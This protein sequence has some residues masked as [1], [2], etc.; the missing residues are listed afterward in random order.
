MIPATENQQIAE[1]ESSS[2]LAARLDLLLQHAINTEQFEADMVRACRKDPE[3]IW[4]LL[5]LLDQ[6]HRLEALPTA[7]F[8]SLKASADRLGL[9]RRE[10]YLPSLTTPPRPSASAAVPAPPPANAPIAPPAPNPALSALQSAPPA[11]PPPLASAITEPPE[12]PA[13]PPPPA[14]AITELPKPA[15]PP[16]PTPAITP[17]AA[18]EP[19]AAAQAIAAAAA[20]AEQHAAA[21]TLNVGSVIGGRYRVEAELESDDRGRIFQALDQQ[22]AGQPAA[23]CQVA[24]HCM[25]PDPANFESILAERR[26]EFQ[27]AQPLSHPNVLSVRELDQDGLYIYL[28]M[29]LMRGETLAALL[30]RRQGRAL[31][32]SAAYA[33]IRDLGAAL[34]YAHDHG[35]VHG[36][37][38]PQCIL[39]SPAGELRV[40]GFG[41]QRASSCYASGEQLENR[42]PDRRDDLYSLACISYELLRGSHPFDRQNASTAR[43]RGMSAARPVRLSGGQWRALRMG[44]AWRRE[45]RNISIARWIGRMHLKA[46]SK[47]LPML[48]DLMAMPAPRRAWWPWILV[49]ACLAAAAIFSASA[50]RMPGMPDFAA[51][52]NAL[53]AAVIERVHTLTPASAPV[54]VTPPPAEAAPAP[55]AA[56][57][58]PGGAIPAPSAEVPA[59]APATAAQPAPPTPPPA[60]TAQSE[61][62]AVAPATTALPAPS[63][64]GSRRAPPAAAIATPKPPPAPAP[65]AAA[66]SAPP[67]PRVSTEAATN[68]TAAK[69]A[70]PAVAAVAPAREVQPAAGPAQIELSADQYSVQPG[71]SAARILVHRTGNTRSEARFVWWTENA[72]ASAD[73]DYVAWGRRVQRIPAG[74]GSVTLLVPIIKDPT[75][76]SARKFYVLI[77]EDGDGGRVSGLTRAAILLPGRG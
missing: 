22:H 26:A 53:R 21:R 54:Q 56:P 29:N 61:P 20:A 44:L 18:P 46:A 52:W 28:T 62:P 23:I 31:A 59:P 17:P 25:Q 68:K 70:V 10:P 14:G 12:P 34:S 63:A 64:F 65:V 69:S 45:G 74:Q 60:A 72:S 2:P 6:Y 77:A 73:Q 19:V 66:P 40:R 15:A 55:E 11:P 3:E 76:N 7:L 9:V 47:R 71:D 49:L 39:I 37:L 75:R 36:N 30:S 48:E 32:R 13:P 4:S 41:A 50:Y 8:R 57:A 35:V 43:G 27:L 38:Q 1:G 33:I 16:P 58:T 42:A 5:A 24:V 67:A 51:G